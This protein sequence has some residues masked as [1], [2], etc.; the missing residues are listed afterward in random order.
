MITETDGHQL[1]EADYNPEMTSEIAQQASDDFL[2]G[3]KKLIRE[4]EVDL[5]DD[6][7]FE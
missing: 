6:V 4:Y 3:I 2:A 7:L 1:S 5:A